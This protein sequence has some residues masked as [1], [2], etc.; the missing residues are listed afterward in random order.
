MPNAELA[1]CIRTAIL[2]RPR[3]YD[4]AAWLRGTS[5]LHPDTPLGSTSPL[6]RTTLRVAV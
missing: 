2:T 5:L 3:H 1:A 4:P 6:S